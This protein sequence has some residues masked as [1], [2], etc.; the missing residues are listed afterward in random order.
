VPLSEHEQR[1]LEQIE[2][3]LLAEDPKFASTV[4]ATDPR[5]Y[6]LRRVVFAAVLV[7]V[8]VG[9]MVFGLVTKFAP[10]GIPVLG[11]L[12]FVVM[13]GAAVLGVQSYR[14][15]GRGEPLRVVGSER[16]PR[17]RSSR[18]SF[19]DRLEERWR[20]RADGER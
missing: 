18:G 11:I 1:L 2:R 7:L 14:R 12:G 6:A 3:A 10:A 13:F 16:K 4:R 20:R 17:G 9:L 5:H 8:G 19:V 15:A